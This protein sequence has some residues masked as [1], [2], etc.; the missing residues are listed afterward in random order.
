M[1]FIY[2]KNPNKMW[3]KILVLLG[4]IILIIMI[5]KLFYG[6][7]W[8]QEGFEQGS[9]YLLKRNGDIID[10]FYIESYEIINPPE[11]WIESQMNTI[12]Q[13]TQPSQGSSVFLDVGSKTGALVDYVAN[14]GYRIYGVEPSEVMMNYSKK[15]YPSI[16]VSCGDVGDSMLFEKKTF[17]HILC[18]QFNIYSFNDK[19][20][21]FRNCFHWLKTG[22]YL[23]VHLVDKPRFNA[24]IPASI[25]YNPFN[26]GSIQYNFSDSP[27]KLPNDGE[28]SLKTTADFNS[29]TYDI[30]YDVQAKSNEV[31]LREKFTDKK[32]SHIRENEKTMY[33]EEM[34]EIVNIALAC[35]FIVQGKTS[36][37]NVNGGDPHQY[38][39]IFERS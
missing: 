36:L 34:G 2:S 37:L 33:M 7:K 19:M 32:T 35:N 39:Y 27:K 12:I 10:D 18:L 20:A 4:L 13:M 6:K 17:S 25:P 8:N 38:L 23:I 22:G 5:F 24:T 3:L 29:F 9:P 21:F 26:W 1:S 14:K 31:L 16:S 15:T 28:R 30:E 11:T